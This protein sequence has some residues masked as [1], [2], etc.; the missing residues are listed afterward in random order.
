MLAA[1]D[2]GV[3]KVRPLLHHVATLMFV[4]GFIVD[5]SRG[6]PIFVGKALLDPIA[7]ETQLIQKG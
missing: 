2:P 6:P 1:L 5:P 4:L 7:V 3:D